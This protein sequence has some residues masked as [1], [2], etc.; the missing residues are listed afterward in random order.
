MAHSAMLFVLLAAAVAVVP[1]SAQTIL[2]TDNNEWVSLTTSPAGVPPVANSAGFMSDLGIIFVYGG[3]FQYQ[4]LTSAQPQAYLSNQLY[5]R[6]IRSSVWLM[7]SIDT[8][9]APCITTMAY[10]HFGIGAQQFL[11]MYG[12]FFMTPCGSIVPIT[13][14]IDVA[15]DLQILDPVERKFYEVQVLSDERPPPLV[16]A[17]LG[18][19]TT[20]PSICEDGAVC[21][22]LIMFG[23]GVASNSTSAAV[24]PQTTWHG[25]LLLRPD[26]NFYVDWQSEAP[27][28]MTPAGRASAGY[29]VIGD[30]FYVVGGSNNL[31]S[32]AFAEDYL[33]FYV[34]GSWGQLKLSLQVQ[35]LGFNLVPTDDRFL[36]IVGGASTPLILLQNTYFLDTING[37]V[38]YMEATATNAFNPLPSRY[39]CIAM[40]WKGSIYA[41]GGRNPLTRVDDLYIYPILLE[42]W[43]SISSLV[44]PQQSLY[45]ATMTFGHSLFQFGGFDGSIPLGTLWVLTPE[46]RW[47]SSSARIQ[48][49]PRFG[50]VMT[51]DLLAS[52]LVLFGGVP[53]TD[54]GSTVWSLIVN[55]EGNASAIENDWLK[56]DLDN[57]PGPRGFHTG[58]LVDNVAACNSS[59]GIYYFGGAQVTPGNTTNAEFSIVYRNDLALL[60]LGLRKFWVVYNAPTD[61]SVPW[62]APRCAHAAAPFGQRVF[63]FGGSTSA[64][65]VDSTT[66]GVLGDA[67]VYENEAWRQLEQP[68]ISPRFSTQYASLAGRL[69]ISGGANLSSSNLDT[70]LFPGGDLRDDSW[71]VTWDE[72]A[73]TAHYELIPLNSGNLRAMG[74]AIMLHNYVF[75]LVGGSTGGGVPVQTPNV[76]VFSPSCGP[77]MVANLTTYV[78]GQACEPCPAGT[79]KTDSGLTPDEPCLP[80]QGGTWTATAGASSPD[81]CNVCE[82]NFCNGHEASPCVVVNSNPVCNCDSDYTGETCASRRADTSLQTAV[83]VIGSLGAA[84]LVAVLIRYFVLRHKRRKTFHV[85]LSYRVAT[86]SALANRVYAK[87]QE[88]TIDRTTQIKVFLDKMCIASGAD[89]ETEFSSALRHSCLFVPIISTAALKPIEQVSEFDEKADNLLYE[90]ELALRQARNKHMCIFPL[91]VGSYEGDEYRPYDDF[92]VTKFP[93]GCSKTYRKGPVWRTMQQLFKIQGCF[94]D[95]ELDPRDE[96]IDQLLQFLRNKA[97]SSVDPECLHLK[98]RWVDEDSSDAS[99]SVASHSSSGGGGIKSSR[100]ALA[101]LRRTADRSGLQ[102]QLLDSSDL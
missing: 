66:P 56:Q 24:F 85:F 1:S 31:N 70:N 5:S 44:Y 42:S 18:V 58:T 51:A 33:Y 63:I 26:G 20:P 86:D 19:L 6:D 68:L 80:C 8:G 90:Y 62:P 93:R 37:T 21:V 41:F 2:P 72:S 76:F 12:G 23:G 25:T 100:A 7:H 32:I 15:D 36:V 30:T 87:L 46:L 4:N 29:A 99:K 45:P 57:A 10:T 102:E 40:Y 71:S 82:P 84:V 14:A 77:G 67:W 34:N 78:S 101:R 11:I 49:E 53:T 9:Y 75:A 22:S 89:W 3:D 97:W 65:A 98:R 52:E 61:T 27:T 13:G 88:R 73:N 17:S 81:Q 54:V 91:L 69:I 96:M 59:R 95:P 35:A 92:D 48:P 50:A 64:P 74:S 16:G 28:A 55:V 83:I 94:V 39:G 47:K 60:C 38:S 43:I 79:Y